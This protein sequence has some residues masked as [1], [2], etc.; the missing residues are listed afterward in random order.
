MADEMDRIVPLDEL[1]DFEVAEGEPD[2]TGWDVISADGRK[3]GEVDQLLVD[4]DAMKVRYLDV[5]VSD[6]LISSGE[7]R[8]ILIPVGYARLN[9]SEDQVLVDTL[10]SSDV[11]SLPEYTHGPVSREFESRLHERFGGNSHRE[12]RT[13]EGEVHMTRS[14]EELVIGKREVQA[15][16]VELDKHVETEHIR[17]PVTRRTEEV[18]IERRPV[19]GMRGR[20]ARIEEEEIHMPLTEEELVVEKRPV[21]KEEMVVRKRPVEETE[22]V[23]TDL[24]RERIDVER[25]GRIEEEEGEQR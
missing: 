12:G 1:E 2:V 10:H 6:D 13:T 7:D 14:E 5:D 9:E 23:E 19:S 20:E 4:T 17:Q 25:H 18:E 24:R 21:V 15:G 22:Q 8:H 11:E 3:I 16:E